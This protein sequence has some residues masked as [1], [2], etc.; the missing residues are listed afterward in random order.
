MSPDSNPLT[1][2]LGRSQASIAVVLSSMWAVFQWQD[3]VVVCEI[4]CF[5]VF[6]RSPLS[7]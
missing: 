3:F 2:Y 7:K 4:L 5:W 6:L 1:V